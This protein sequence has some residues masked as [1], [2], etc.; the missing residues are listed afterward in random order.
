MCLCVCWYKWAV[1]LCEAP[2]GRNNICHSPVRWASVSVGIHSLQ[3]AF[4]GEHTHITMKICVKLSFMLNPFT[5][6]DYR[7]CIIRNGGLQRGELGPCSTAANKNVL[8]IFM[9]W[10]VLIRCSL[11]DSKQCRIGTLKVWHIM[12]LI[13]CSS[14][15]SWIV[16]YR[17]YEFSE[18]SDTDTSY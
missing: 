12:W 5:R 16:K 14:I 18:L 6:R 1:S 15:D 7:H 11:S 13:E 8:F 9:C 3:L 2:L 4:T 17:C 10:I